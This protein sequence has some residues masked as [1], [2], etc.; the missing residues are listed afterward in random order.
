M[1][2]AKPAQSFVCPWCGRMVKSSRSGF[3]ASHLTAGGLKCYAVGMRTE[4]ARMLRELM[5]TW[6][7]KENERTRR[8]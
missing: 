2:R 6:E 5:E 3:V 1:P 7:G 4:Q 8:R